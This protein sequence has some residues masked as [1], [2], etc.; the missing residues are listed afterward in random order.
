MLPDGS[1]RWLETHGEQRIVSGKQVVGG[2]VQDITER[3]CSE[4]AL[5]EREN[6]LRSIIEHAPIPIIL[7]REDRKVL[8]MNPTLTKLTGYTASDIP[9]RDEWEALAYRDDAPQGKEDFDRT[10]ERGRPIDI[11]NRWVHT[12][13]GE[14][15]LWSLTRAPA[16]QDASGRRL[17][18]GVATDITE[19]TKS[20]E[21]ALATKSKLE[22]ALA[23]M[24]DG[25]FILD[26][27]GRFIDFNEAFAKFHKFKSKED[28]VQTF[29]ELPSILSFFLPGG[30]RVP[31]EEW[32]SQ[33]ALRGET[34]LQV[35][36]TIKQR[37]GE[38]YIGSYN[39]AP[40]R[41]S[42]GHITG[43]VVSVRD[44][45]DQKR[46]ANRLS[47]SEARLS[48]IIDTAADSIVVIDDKGM[49]QSANRAT[50][51]IFGYDLED[52]VG[53]DIGILMPSNLAA[54]HNRYLNGFSGRG[55]VREVAA[56]RKD[57]TMV[58]IDGAVTEWRDGEG[59][60][61]FTGILR[62]LT[63]ANATRKRWQTHVASKPWASSQAASR[64]ISII[65]CTS[66]PAIWKSPRISSRMKQRGV[67]L[68][69]RATP[70][71]REAP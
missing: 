42:S 18:V 52:L 31:P 23:A 64:T 40:I 66:S 60:R 63:S 2:L 7:W 37:Y 15:R 14:K 59:R 12:K 45:T 19:R 1:I 35:E 68:S 51:G 25:V 67:S 55:A 13:S 33:R 34:E 5:R 6:I 11:G 43:A 27:E 38:A 48:S 49:I 30:E 22:A 3:K 10:F 24:R 16:G 26:A 50:E 41:D 47:E 44:I 56:K 20:E 70:P 32:P 8:L 9:T 65:F 62:D 57:G 17:V 54:Q 21:E 46:A 69:A 29:A 71:K 58:P 39:F 61:F 28:C 4:Q 36:Y 53:R